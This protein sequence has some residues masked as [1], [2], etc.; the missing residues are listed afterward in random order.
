MFI[1]NRYYDSSANFKSIL[2]NE[3]EDKHKEKKDKNVQ[4]PAITLKQVL[5]LI[6][7]H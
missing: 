4:R 5:G 2:L 3:Y 6:F 1:F 7:D